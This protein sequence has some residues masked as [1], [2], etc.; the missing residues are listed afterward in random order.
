[1]HV[2][3][4]K[5]CTDSD[6]FPRSKHVRFPKKTGLHALGQYVCRQMALDTHITNNS[7]TQSIDKNLS[8]TLIQIIRICCQFGNIVIVHIFLFQ[9]YLLHNTL[10]TISHYYNDDFLLHI[11]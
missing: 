6:E 3:C 4:E 11:Y 9:L 8:I 5:C 10:H 7:S 1:M 2:S